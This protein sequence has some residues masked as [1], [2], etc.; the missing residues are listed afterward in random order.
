MQRQCTEHRTET[1]ARTPRG[2]NSS[3]PGDLERWRLSLERVRWWR[4]LLLRWRSLRGEGLKTT[5]TCQPATNPDSKSLLFKEPR[6]KSH[7]RLR[8][9]LLLLGGEKVTVLTCA[10]AAQSN[11]ET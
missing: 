10:T 9:D 1:R 5:Q 2:R 11:T 8:G 3:V 4:G 6:L 7:L